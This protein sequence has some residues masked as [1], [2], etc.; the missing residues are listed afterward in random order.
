MKTSND[1]NSNNCLCVQIHAILTWQSSCT[2]V[3]WLPSA[4]LAKC[5]ASREI[6]AKTCRQGG[7]TWLYRSRWY[8]RMWQSLGVGSPWTSQGRVSRPVRNGFRSNS[9]WSMTMR[10]AL[11]TTRSRP[12]NGLGGD[13]ENIPVLQDDCC[14]WRLSVDFLCQILKREKKNKIIEWHIFHKPAMNLIIKGTRLELWQCPEF[15]EYYIC[16]VLSNIKK[17]EGIFF[18]QSI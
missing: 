10:Q 12:A 3:K 16:H 4:K 18:I 5:G 1:D 6:A 11:R 17:G 13:R 15:P 8:C 14:C 7:W 9:S 2:S